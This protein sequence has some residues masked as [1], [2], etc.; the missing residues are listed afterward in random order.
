MKL[1]IAATIPAC[2]KQ[3]FSYK[4][5]SDMRKHGI[6]LG[7]Y[8]LLRVYTPWTTKAADSDYLLTSLLT[9]RHC[10]IIKDC[11]ISTG[12]AILTQFLDVK[13][14]VTI[15]IQSDDDIIGCV[16]QFKKNIFGRTLRRVIIDE[17][18]YPYIDSK[19]LPPFKLTKRIKDCKHFEVKIS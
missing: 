14:E 15:D 2:A 6:D 18:Q 7:D 19:S 3:R 12:E 13:V 16:K 5:H 9:H 1:Y 4:T 8:F 17:S 10:D 11:V